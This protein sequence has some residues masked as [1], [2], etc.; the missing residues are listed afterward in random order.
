[1]IRF[2]ASA[3]AAAA[4]FACSPSQPPETPE[5][6]PG[7]RP[8][9]GEPAASGEPGSPAAPA[10][11]AMP[12]GVVKGGDPEGKG[13]SLDSYELTPSDCEALGRQYGAVIRNDMLAGLSPKLA[14]KQ[15]AATTAQIEDLAGK[16]ADAWAGSCQTNLVNKAVDHAA[17]TCALASKA[18]KQFDVCL[19][20]EGGT[21]Q[22]GKPAK[23]K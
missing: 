15:R 17:L 8:S 3:L 23:K 14:D 19:N 12:G 9:S 1:M 13:Q 11:T 20:G 22:P 4:L 7:E 18:V 5:S 10:V 2:V 6:V 21:P 16:K